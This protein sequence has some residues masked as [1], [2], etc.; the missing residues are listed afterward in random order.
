MQ[1][2]TDEQIAQYNEDGYLVASGLIPEDVSER[3]E[4]AIWRLMGIDPDDP[5][6]WGHEPETAD[7]FQPG[8]GLSVFNGI[9]DPDIMAC[10]TP[11]YLKATAELVGEESVHPPESAHMQNKVPIN[12][13]WSL[14]RAHIDGLPKEHMHQTFPGPY[15]IASLVFVSNVEHKG[16]GTAVFPGSHRK[17]LELASSD[18]AKYEYIIPLNKDLSTLDLG[19]PVELTPRRG[20]ILFFTYS[21]GHNGTNN[22]GNQP[23]WMMRYMCSCQACHTRWPKAGEWALWTP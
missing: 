6:S 21:F 13:E 1:V 12:G 8:R 18:R 20:D 10:V 2:L 22:V 11:E 9:R 23:R 5:E 15:R 7:Q 16:G 4:A 17:I 14:P 19:D 3:A